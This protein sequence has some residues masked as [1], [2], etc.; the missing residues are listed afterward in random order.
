MDK[1]YKE[2]KDITIW[3]EDSEEAGRQVLDIFFSN[4]LQAATIFV[5][6]VFRGCGV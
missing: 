2:K 3:V 1:D 4:N 5:M 6:P